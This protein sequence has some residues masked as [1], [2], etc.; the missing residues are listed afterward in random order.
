MAAFPAPC[1]RRAAAVHPL[2]AVDDLAR[3]ASPTARAAAALSSTGLFLGRSIGSDLASRHRLTIEQLL[4]S[5][6]RLSLVVIRAGSPALQEFTMTAIRTLVALSV[7]ALATACASPGAM[8]ASPGMS[9]MA[10]PASMATM[11]PRMMA[12]QEMHQKMT[13]AKT[14]AERQ[15]LM[16]DHMKAMQ[17]GMAM[18][19]EMHGGMQGM[20][21]MGGMQGMAGMGGS[22]GMP[23]DMAQRHQKMT[24]HMAMMQMMMD[25]MADRMPAAPV[26]R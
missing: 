5:P 1:F 6:C 13:A 19:K 26:T 10:A 3:F 7:A 14:P 21:G 25:M 18:M 8:N 24:D 20:G 17:G 22:K 16:A 23:A 9:G 4:S 2:A 15:A 12:M 11:Q